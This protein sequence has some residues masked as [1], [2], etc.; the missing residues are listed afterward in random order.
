MSLIPPEDAANRSISLSYYLHYLIEN[1]N[2]KKFW[3][4]AEEYFGK[5]DGEQKQDKF[6]AWLRR[7]SDVSSGANRFTL[8]VLVKAF[9]TFYG[10][11]L[12]DP[13]WEGFAASLVRLP[14]T[15]MPHPNELIMKYQALTACRLQMNE[16]AGTIYDCLRERVCRQTQALLMIYHSSL[17]EIAGAMNMPAV[18][19]EQIISNIQTALR[20]DLLLMAG[21][22][23]IAKTEDP[24][25]ILSAFTYMYR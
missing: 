2:E 21:L 14:L 22:G 16:R 3:T 11:R 20:T 19:T 12:P 7:F 25:Q 10:K 4:Y 13:Q 24:K 23:K 17:L 9:W 15:D 8:F 18:E 1:S 6:H 5:A